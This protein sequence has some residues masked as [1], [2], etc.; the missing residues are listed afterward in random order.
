MPNIICLL[1]GKPLL[2]NKGTKSLNLHHLL[3][4][5]VITLTNAPHLA[6]IVS[7]RSLLTIPET[8]RFWI[9]NRVSFT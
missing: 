1:K 9:G 8:K 4:V 3:L 6:P 7:P 2:A 5:L